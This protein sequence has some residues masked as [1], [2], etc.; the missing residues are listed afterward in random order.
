MRI[1]DLSRQTGMS[2]ATIKFYIREGLL[3]P[4]RLTARNQAVYSECHLRRLQLIRAL[5]TVGGLGLASVRT[6]LEAIADDDLPLA[7]LY[8]I[9]NRTICA[10]DPVIDEIVA[11]EPVREDVDRFFETLGWDPDSPARQHI[12]AMMGTLRSLGGADGMDFFLPHA[13]AAAELAEQEMDLL[14]SDGMKTDRA[15]AVLRAVLFGEV[16]SSLRRLAQEHQA[17]QRFRA[18]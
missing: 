1:S 17:A 2:T 6:L 7:E 8:A 12:V 5:T 16:L 3:P 10:H 4:G 15:A 13:R 9:V 18:A 14:P 11:E